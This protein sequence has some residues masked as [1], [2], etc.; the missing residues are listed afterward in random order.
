M[1]PIQGGQK[2][3]AGGFCLEQQDATYCSGTGRIRTYKMVSLGVSCPV[4]RSFVL[5]K[6]IGAGRKLPQ[7]GLALP[8]VQASQISAV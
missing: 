5:P 6:L 2:V 4:R 3:W 8:A 7:E 1:I